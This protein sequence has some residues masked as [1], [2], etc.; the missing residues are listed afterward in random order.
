[1]A[2]PA[3]TWERGSVRPSN[4]GGGGGKDPTLFGGPG[5]LRWN[6]SITPLTG[7]SGS[8]VSQKV[9]G[10]NYTLIEKFGKR[11]LEILGAHSP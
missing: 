2:P 7:W 6:H 4:R 3:G 1:M 8:N 5:L 9:F 10:G 11:P